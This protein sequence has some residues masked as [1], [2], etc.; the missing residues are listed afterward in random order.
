[1]GAGSWG[2]PVSGGSFPAG[3]WGHSC[4]GA[5]EG[6]AWPVARFLSLFPQRGPAIP[7]G[8]SPCPA[9]LTPG[10]GSQPCLP[11]SPAQGG[12]TPAERLPA[13]GIPLQPWETF[14]SLEPDLYVL[15]TEV[16][17]ANTVTFVGVL[18]AGSSS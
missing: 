14:V 18:P 16:C 11:P 8:C 1:M 4:P 5:G 17:R 13:S 9:L 3:A 12:T 10:V 7:Q 6:G 2:L 15:K